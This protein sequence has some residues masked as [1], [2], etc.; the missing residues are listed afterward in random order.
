MP[1]IVLTLKN[2]IRQIWFDCYDYYFF[3][4]CLWFNVANDLIWGCLEVGDDKFNHA[5]V[6]V[7]VMGKIVDECENVTKNNG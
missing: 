7:K 1:K 2:N 6:L 4:F 5:K 3:V